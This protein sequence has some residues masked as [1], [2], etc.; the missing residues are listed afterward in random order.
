MTKKI[1]MLCL[2]AGAGFKGFGQTQITGKVRDAQTSHG[3]EYATISVTDAAT[4]KVLDG[5]SADTL[6]NFNIK[7]L[8]KGKYTL[9]ISFLGYDDYRSDTLLL[10]TTGQTLQLPV[11]QLHSSTHTLSDVVIAAQ[12]PVVEHKI[13]KIV[14][15]AANDLTAQGGVALDVLKKVPQV[16]VDV[17]GNV[18]LQGNSNIRFLIN[19]KPSSV[20]GN[21]LTDALS[22]IPASQIKSIEAITSPG[23][24]YDA[25]GTGGIINIILKDNKIKG[26][27]GSINGA[28]GTRA[29]NASIN[30]NAR[31]GDVG[32]NAF[33]SGNAMLRAK[34]L[35]SQDRTSVS[36]PDA[37]STQ[38]LQ[39]GYNNLSR[40]GMQTGIGVDWSAT[41]RDIFTAS[42][43]YSKFTNQRDG[44]THLS[45][46]VTD[47]Q[48]HMVSGSNSS[49]NATSSMDNHALDWALSYKHKFRHEGEELNI[50]YNASYGK[51]M[52]QYSQQ[53]VYRGEVMPYSGTSS[54]NPGTNYQNNISVDY[55]R[56]FSSKF[57]LEAG[58]K[59]IF[60][61]ISSLTDVNSL[62][63][64]SGRYIY[65]PAQSYALHYKM[66]I[67]AGYVAAT[68]SLFHYIDLKAG[69]RIEHTDIGIDYQHTKIP[70]YNTYVPS[71]I[72]SHK[73]DD[74]RFVKLA[75]THRIER[76]D[77]EELNP[78]LNLSDPYNITTGNPLLKP[79][80]GDNFELGYGKSFA[81]GGNLY[82]SL[83][84]RIN[85]QDI[86]P[87]TQFYPDYV[88]GDSTY[89][90]IS[91]TNKRNI[92]TEYN[93]GLMLSGSFPVIPHLNA[94]ANVM[95][96]NRHIV[97]NLAGAN[98]VT[99]SFSCNVNLNINYLL[100]HDLVAEIFGNYKSPFNNIQ[101]KNPQFF[102]YTIA[103]RKQFWDKKAS[104]GVTTTNPFAN[105]VKQIT[106]I[107]S[108][109]Y[110]AYNIREI[111]LRSFGIVFGYRFGK[112]DFGKNNK[113]D[114][115]IPDLP[116]EN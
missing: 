66:N 20:F 44:I 75:Y 23:A 25:Q 74:N 43:Q 16:S 13:D 90:N 47:E 48:G 58:A 105:A 100:P 86:K 28:V 84:E 2:L 91:V 87:F 53:Q 65:D 110:S 72:L 97:N 46:V 62:S 115:G 89:N 77:Y 111:P 85:S 76:P 80:L 37:T 3:I 78:F 57:L 40:N 104:L 67:Y 96:F 95:V 7:D 103:V 26:I 9:S 56:P 71:V 35:N 83:V 69:L 60:H 82:V 50:D 21:S 15:N 17:D 54:Y 27:N 39:D 30:L 10:H 52:L 106:T 73:L 1:A 4:G 18:E 12:A 113:H 102:T 108:D 19:G 11:I 79:E 114:H 55:V 88:I 68:F 5:A 92:G 99:N 59:S 33:F 51:P 107:N 101:G 93:S 45:E 63:P 32:I 24:K 6:G 116:G 14:F 8:P 112:L 31:K 34:S 64:A 94:R 41:K 70:P 109:A 42:F 49:R 29:E 61:H 38:L 81:N 36:T 98:P 22:S